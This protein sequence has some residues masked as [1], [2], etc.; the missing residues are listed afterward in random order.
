MAEITG[1]D[2]I[3]ESLIA[4]DVDTMFG[5]PGGQ[6]DHFF[7]SIHRTNGA[8]NII[9][10]RHEQGAAYM[11]FGYAQT[12]GRPGIYAVVPGPGLLNTAAAL[13]TPSRATP[14]TRKRRSKIRTMASGGGGP[15]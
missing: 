14:I 15:P 3:V 10:S 2:A 4:N 6:L 12:T 8:I 11:A 13:C 5:L 9:H 1:A 7:D